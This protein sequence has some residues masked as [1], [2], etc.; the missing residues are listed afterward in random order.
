MFEE[1]AA[2]RISRWPNHNHAVA[3][4]L[5]RLVHIPHITVR[6]GQAKKTL[7]PPELGLPPPDDL[8]QA[9][10]FHRQDDCEA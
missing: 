6:L 4:R 3:L 10:T 1:H 7:G 9:K 2:L 8:R 5:P